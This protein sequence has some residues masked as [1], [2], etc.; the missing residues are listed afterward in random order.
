MIYRWYSVYDREKYSNVGIA[1]YD[2]NMGIA[3]NA[4]IPAGIGVY[5]RKR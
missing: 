5:S 4:V 2:E 1:N 3:N